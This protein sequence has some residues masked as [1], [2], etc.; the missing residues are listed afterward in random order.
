MASSTV[1]RTPINK[2]LKHFETSDSR[3]HSILQKIDIHDWFEDH[4]LNK[5]EESLFL[6]L[7]REIIGQQLSVGAATTIFNRF[8]GHFQ[9]VTPRVVVKVKDNNLRNLGLSW[10]KVSYIRDLAEKVANGTLNL[11]ELKELSDEEV[12]KRL[13]QVKG[14][15][16]WTAEMFLMFTLGREDVFSYGDLGLQKGFNKVYEVDKPTRKHITEVVEKWQPYRSYGSIAL[17]SSLEE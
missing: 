9:T 8:V 1:T 15:G 11:K 10:S 7:C 6:A 16:P 2:I 13:L 12:L 5:N 3:I 4:Y 17:W 14:I